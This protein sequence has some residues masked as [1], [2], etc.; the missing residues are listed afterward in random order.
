MITRD[1]YNCCCKLNSSGF[2]LRSSSSSKLRMCMSDTSCLHTCFENLQ[3]YLTPPLRNIHGL[4]CCWLCLKKD[5]CVVQVAQ[6]YFPD[7]SC[8][9]HLL[10]EANLWADSKRSRSFRKRSRRLSTSTDNC[11]ISLLICTCRWSTSLR[12]VLVN[13]SAKELDNDSNPA[14]KRVHVKD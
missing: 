13:R 7:W 14:N 10:Q 1:S 8:T 2:R 3:L 12:I 5:T 6:E 11:F 9:S 4:A